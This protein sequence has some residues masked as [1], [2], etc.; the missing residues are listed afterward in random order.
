MS[1]PWQQCLVAAIKT[2]TIFAL[3]TWQWTSA[4]S[5]HRFWFTFGIPKL[6]LRSAFS[7]TSTPESVSDIV[8]SFCV[9]VRMLVG[10][11]DQNYALLELEWT[12]WQLTKICIAHLTMKITIFL[13]SISVYL[14]HSKVGATI[15]FLF[16]FHTRISVRHHFLFLC[17]RSN[18]RCLPRS[19][20]CAFGTGMDRMTTPVNL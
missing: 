8:F 1:Q 12:G 14:W 4:F 3:L 17:L 18:A 10:F 13:P 15:S 11:A 16:D 5:F 7:L 20:L 19:K 6:G 2:V 9:C